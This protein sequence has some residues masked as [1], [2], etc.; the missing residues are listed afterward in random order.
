MNDELKNRLL[1]LAD[2]YV[3]YVEDMCSGRFIDDEERRI[4]NSQRMLVHNELNSILKTDRRSTNM[5]DKCREIIHE[6]RS[7]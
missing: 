2:E 4:I 6:S 5:Y 3:G 1:A 7:I